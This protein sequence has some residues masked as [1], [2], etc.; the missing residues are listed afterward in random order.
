MN[1]SI[2]EAGI[3]DFEYIVDYFRNAT[4]DYLRQMGAEKELLPPRTEWIASIQSDWMKP[5]EE[6]R[7]CYIIWYA[8][9]RA[10]GHS[11]INKIVYGEQANM[12]LH[13][14]FPEFRKSGL[15]V[16]L[17]RQA[18]PKYFE[19]FRLKLLICEPYAHNPAPRK[20]LEKLGF[21]FERTYETIPGIICNMQEVSRFTLREGE[22]LLFNDKPE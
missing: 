2:E 14:W 16:R 17:L 20:T 11:N 1:L 15:G 6:K 18:I 21:K 4:P 19:Y 3:T 12:H 7:M 8:D 5:L 10:I 13:I 22:L 9:G